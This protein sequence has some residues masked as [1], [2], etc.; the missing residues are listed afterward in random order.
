MDSDT[1]PDASHFS[2]V[3]GEKSA[4]CATAPSSLWRF[5]TSKEAVLV[6]LLIL[7]VSVILRVRA[8]KEARS[9]PS[10]TRG[11]LEVVAMAQGELGAREYVPQRVSNPLYSI[12]ILFGLNFTDDW[13][14][15]S[16]GVVMA[17]SLV[18]PLLV[19]LVAWRFE[20]RLWAGAL[21]GL[22]A[23]ASSPLI[24]LSTVPLATAT[25]IVFYTLTLL[26]C[27]AFVRKPTLRLAMLGGAFG[28]L[29]WAT[30]GPGLFC[31]IAMGLPMLMAM[32]RSEAPDLP[33]GRAF[34][35]LA[36][37]FVAFVACGRGPS[38]ALQPYAKGLKPSVPYVKA[39]IVEG[40]MYLQGPRYRDEQVYALNEDCTEFRMYEEYHNTSLLDLVR[41]YG[42]NQFQAYVRNLGKSFSVALPKALSPFFLLFLPFAIGIIH[43]WRDCPFLDLRVLVLFAFPFLAIIPGI[44]LNDRYIYPVAPLL[45]PVIGVGLVRMWSSVRVLVRRP[46]TARV[47]MV[48]IV[49]GTLAYG[50]RRSRVLSGEH[51]WAEAYKEACLWLREKHK[52]ESDV[53]VMARYHGAYAWLRMAMVPLPVDDIPRVTRY[54]LNSGTRYIIVSPMEFAHNKHLRNTLRY[55]TSVKVGPAILRIVYTAREGG[56]DPV[57]VLEVVPL[58]RAT[59]RDRNEAQSA[60]QS[61]SDE[62]EPKSDR[63]DEDDGDEE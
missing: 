10:D 35:M 34:G 15:A 11:F 31:L 52:G 21:A 47:A 17:M 51:G 3:Q 18:L 38:L 41:K 1:A 36:A 8:A 28:G 45:L 39:C 60:T 57:R 6:F 58:H 40:G 48:V 9:I 25:F 49:L 42:G 13:L 61:H 32:R 19:C 30:W 4:T 7:V 56:S 63:S 53:A 2:E 22:L 50:Y 12:L 59:D 29:A 20:Q 23:A 26:V 37:F 62:D 55:K 5:A 43:L 54:C 14:T 46:R 33:R 16:K 24:R 44:Q 27:L